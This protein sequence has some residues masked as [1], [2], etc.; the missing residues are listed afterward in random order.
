MNDF[1]WKKRELLVKQLEFFGCKK[2]NFISEYA[3]KP[4]ICIKNKVEVTSVDSE[5]A[6]ISDLYKQQM[7][8]GMQ[9]SSFG[10]NAMAAAQYMQGHPGVGFLIG[11]QQDDRARQQSQLGQFGFLGNTY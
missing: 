10:Y 2:V 7:D 3:K 8:N 4:R 5:R 1:R 9:R 6:T 11:G